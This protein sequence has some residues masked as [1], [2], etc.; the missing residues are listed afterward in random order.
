MPDPRLVARLAAVEG[1]LEQALARLAAVARE[2]VTADVV[3]VEVTEGPDGPGVG[4]R[5]LSGAPVAHALGELLAAGVRD[6]IRLGELAVRADGPAHWPTPPADTPDPVRARALNER[7]GDAGA[8]ARLLEGA[9]GTAVPLRVGGVAF[10]CLS[11][12]GLA[13]GTGLPAAAANDLAALAA[14]V[15]L[16]ARA[17]QLAALAGRDRERLQGVIAAGKAGIIVTDG[18]GLMVAANRAVDELMGV[19]VSDWTGRPLRELLAERLKWRV[20]NPDDYQARLLPLLDDPERMAD[21]EVDTVLGRTLEHYSAPVRD[22]ARRPLGRVEVLNDVTA[23]R[24]A[25]AAANRLAEERAALLEREERRAQEETALARAGHSLASALTEAEVQEELIEQAFR[26]V[27][28]DKAALLTVDAR[29]DILP[30]AER[31]FAPGTVKRMEFSLG[32]GIVGRVL[33]NRRPFVSNDTA[34]DARV[35]GRITEPEGIRS[36]MHMPLVVGERVYGLLSLNCLTPRAYGERELRVVDQLARHAA[37]ALQNALQFE[38]ERHIAQTLQQALLAEDLPAVPGL[39]LAALYQSSAGAQVGGD[40]YNAWAL[41]SGELAVL[42]GDVSGKGVEAAGVTAM[43]RYMTEALSQRPCSP[44]SLLGELND[45]LCTRLADGALVTVFLAALAPG[46]DRMTWSS[47]G[48]PPPALVDGG[49][50]LRWLE[51]PGPPCGVFPGTRYEDHDEPFAPGALLFAYTDGLTEAR[52]A[53]LEF[54]EGGVREALLEALGET[55]RALAR[56]VY[57][58]ARAWSDGR[59]ADDVAIAVASRI[60]S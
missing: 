19:P 14:P 44:A 56:S 43:V 29:G 23:A 12:M 2:R 6:P 50:A 45:L 11:A 1:T 20:K 42:L 24:T 58:A 51:D 57:A 7:R 9:L 37:S 39:A 10:G 33:A 34:S 26:L 32:E 48:H 38:Q 5:A 21:I 18:A 4:G 28:C 40:L 27:R 3:A 17:H 41:P 54:G 25:L 55:P 49:R 31:G 59:I 46:A 8:M 13:G 22:A 52:R 36:F 30:V 35:S 53:G 60:R 47:A 16:A 15:A